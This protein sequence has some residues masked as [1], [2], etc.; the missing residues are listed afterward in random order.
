[1]MDRICRGCRTW[2]NSKGL[3]LDFLVIVYLS[4]LTAVTT[5]NSLVRVEYLY[6]SGVD[7]YTNE[8]WQA[9]WNSISKAREEFNIILSKESQCKKFCDETFRD[10]NANLVGDLDLEFFA[11]ALRISKCLRKCRQDE[12]MPPLEGLSTNV[13]DDLL[14]FKDYEYL[15]MCAFKVGTSHI[16]VRTSE[17]Y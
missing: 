16:A 13:R 7:S 17:Q 15:Q 5:E 12:A 8:D 6:S 14:A 10:F 11:G 2:T 9:C 4:S 1:M 3:V